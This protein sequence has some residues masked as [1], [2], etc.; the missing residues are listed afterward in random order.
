MLLI[1]RLALCHQTKPYEG[2]KSQ[3]YIKVQKIDLSALDI[4]IGFKE[5]FII[6]C[7]SNSLI[8]NAWVSEA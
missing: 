7:R 3:R 5:I 2:Y 8:R 1:R 6:H 4:R